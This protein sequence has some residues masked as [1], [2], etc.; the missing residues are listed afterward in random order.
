MAAGATL[1]L[2]EM[3]LGQHLMLQWQR[4][5]VS[6]PSFPGG[7]LDLALSD[8]TTDADGISSG[9]R[10]MPKLVENLSK[11]GLGDPKHSPPAAEGAAS[12]AAPLPDE[13]APAEPIPFQSDP[14]TAVTEAGVGASDVVPPGFRVPGMSRPPGDDHDMEV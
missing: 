14:Y 6:S 8:Y 11:A 5:G 4:G 2:R 10:D 9:Y 12:R 7:S 3:P 13:S 1:Y